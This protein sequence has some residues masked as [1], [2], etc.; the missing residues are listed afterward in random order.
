MDVIKKAQKIIDGL[1]LDFQEFSMER[2]VEAV[3][4]F[5]GCR[6]FMFAIP[7]EPQGVWVRD[8]HEPNVYI[9]YNTNLSP[10]HQV[11]AQLHEIGH[12]LFG[13]Q[14]LRVPQGSLAELIQI[15]KTQI[16]SDSSMLLMRDLEGADQPDYDRME[17]EAEAIAIVVQTRAIQASRLKQLSLSVSDNILAGDLLRNMGLE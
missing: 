14:T 11:N 1:P 16:A 7:M 9:F 17:D 4:R 10:I 2:F 13:H 5:T 6:L 12:F 3:Q 8:E 15:V